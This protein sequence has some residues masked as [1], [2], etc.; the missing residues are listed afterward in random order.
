[1]IATSLREMSCERV[2]CTAPQKGQAPADEIIKEIVAATASAMN[3]AMFRFF[4]IAPL[5]EVGRRQIGVVGQM[6]GLFYPFYK[7]RR[8]SV[9]ELGIGGWQAQAKSRPAGGTGKRSLPVLTRP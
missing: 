4:M 8:Q 2:D 3:P 9:V 7:D 5:C 6:A 1:M